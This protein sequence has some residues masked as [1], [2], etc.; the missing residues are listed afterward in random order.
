MLG[1]IDAILQIRQK[2]P[3]KCLGGFRGRRRHGQAETVL[4]H[5]SALLAGAAKDRMIM[6]HPGW[7]QFT[8]SRREKKTTER[9]I[10]TDGTLICSQLQL[11]SSGNAACRI[12][13]TRQRRLSDLTDEL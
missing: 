2:R 8:P 4:W 6:R 7:E 10:R 9:S 13:P 3:I 12:S 1:S 5:C 11:T